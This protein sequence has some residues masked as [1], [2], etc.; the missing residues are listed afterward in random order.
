MTF[1]LRGENMKLSRKSK[2][3]VVLLMIASS[4]CFS[5]KWKGIVKGIEGRVGGKNSSQS[6]SESSSSG[7]SS[8]S[9]SSGFFSN[10]GS[11]G[12]YSDI[13]T[14]KSKKPAKL[15]KEASVQKHYKLYEKAEN[16]LLKKDY[17]TAQKYFDEANAIPFTEAT[18]EADA[19]ALMDWAGELGRYIGTLNSPSEE[20]KDKWR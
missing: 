11:N 14:Y 1:E 9:S 20:E 5:Q 2:V 16:A 10:F 19:L 6:S 7:S 12:K 13:S 15:S 3:A 8:S 17:K 18:P 4:A